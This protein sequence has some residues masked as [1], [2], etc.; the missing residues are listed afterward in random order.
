LFVDSSAFLALA[1]ARDENH[2]RAR[3]IQDRVIAGGWRLLTTTY[4]VAELHALA[5]ARRGSR[6]ALDLIDRIDQSDV[7]IV[8]VLEE[9]WRQARSILGRHD[10]KKFSFTDALSFAVMDRLGIRDA[11]TFDRHFLQYGLQVLGE[12]A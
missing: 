10:D 11:F 1:S 9:D 7:L 8:R 2:E 4:V 12:E 6:F 5:L 3:R